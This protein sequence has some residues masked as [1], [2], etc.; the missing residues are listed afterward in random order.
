MRWLFLLT[1]L[2]GFACG[3]ADVSCKS[4]ATTDDGERVEPTMSSRELEKELDDIEREIAG[5]GGRR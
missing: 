5:D 2:L 4:C 3:N 1:S